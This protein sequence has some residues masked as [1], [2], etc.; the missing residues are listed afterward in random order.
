[1]I[2][3]VSAQFDFNTRLL[4]NAL[5]GINDAES[6]TPIS[7]NSNTI[8]WIVG[9]LLS[10]RLNSLSKI[11]GIPPDTTLS[12][13]FGRDSKMSADTVY[14]TLPELSEKWNN[15]AHEL[16]TAIAQIP[17][18]KLTSKSGA[19]LPINNDSVLG[20]L[21]FLMAHESLHIGQLT[22]LRKMMG[23]PAMS[24]R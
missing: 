1:M 19:T 7:E 4:N 9:H 5:D 11:A 13:L 15:L 8:K 23:K 20:M 2:T 14:P 18:E 12:P 22:V 3:S 6:S 16:G 10:I 17:T 24:Y 21:A